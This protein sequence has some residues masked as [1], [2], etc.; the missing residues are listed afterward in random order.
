MEQQPEKRKSRE[1]EQSRIGDKPTN[2]EII[3]NSIPVAEIAVHV[4]WLFF[5]LSLSLFVLWFFFDLSLAKMLA[6]LF[7]PRRYDS[8][9]P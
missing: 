3:I 2:G 8:E 6:C 5:I 4:S 1:T 9:G 7:M